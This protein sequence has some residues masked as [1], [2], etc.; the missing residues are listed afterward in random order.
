M[1]ADLK[2]DR[3]EC[4]S[5]HTAEYIASL[6]GL[7]ILFNLCQN[8]FGDFDQSISSWPLLS[9]AG[10]NKKKSETKIDTRFELPDEFANL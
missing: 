10:L 5:V 9:A 3:I 1:T 8:R 2:Y 4:Q 6:F 7:A